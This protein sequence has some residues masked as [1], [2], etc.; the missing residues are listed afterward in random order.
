VAW[1]LALVLI[2]VGIAGTVLPGVPGPI[3]VF[4]GIVVAA[5]GDGFAR[6]GIG[7]LVVLGIL[8]AATYAIDFA[9]SALGV[10]RVGASMRAVVGAALGVI[11]G[12]FFGL[13]GLVLGPFVGAVLAELTVHGD[14]RAAGRAGVAAWIGL[15]VG[16]ALK[17]TLVFV[18]LGVA[19]LML[20]LR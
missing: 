10:R 4:A 8:T 5:W 15:V 7:T 11:V 13:P 17:I 9:A 16:A 6:I 19:V 20:F 1:I 12:L 14:L 3:L 2:L 18:M